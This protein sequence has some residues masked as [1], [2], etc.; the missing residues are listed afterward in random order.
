MVS[1]CWIKSITFFLSF[2]KTAF[3]ENKAVLWRLIDHVFYDSFEQ[4]C[5]RSKKIKDSV[6]VW[7]WGPQRWCSRQNFKETSLWPTEL[8]LKQWTCLVSSLYHSLEIS[9]SWMSCD[10][11]HE[12]RGVNWGIWHPAWQHILQQ[13]RHFCAVSRLM[14]GFPSPLCFWCC[15]SN[16]F[17]TV[18]TYS[19]GVMWILKSF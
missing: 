3:K 14:N 4:C 11:V 10:P 15:S 6:S 9:F 19:T 5:W 16:C 13:K 8:L 18:F 2:V 1:F 12:E 7:L 17:Y